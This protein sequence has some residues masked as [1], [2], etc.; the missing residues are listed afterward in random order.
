V[1]FDRQIV[2]IAKVENA[3]TIYSDDDHLKSYGEKVGIK[4]V[5]VSDLP[6]PPP[7]TG[8]LPFD[9]SKKA[10]NQTI[11]DEEERN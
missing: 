9:E 10:P 7:A 1:K 8:S 4:V 2:A 3:H 11:E 5:S 6:L